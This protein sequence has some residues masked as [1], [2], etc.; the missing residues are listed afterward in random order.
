MKTTIRITQNDFK[1]LVR[2]KLKLFLSVDIVGSTH[3]KQRDKDSHAQNWLSLFLSFFAEFPTIFN[4]EIA[5]Q[6]EAH[7]H[8]GLDTVRL[9]KSLGDELIF[10]VELKHRTQAAVYLKAF[11]WA[12]REAAANWHTDSEA[13]ALKELHLKGAA[14]LAGFPVG[15]AE[16]P[17]EVRVDEKSMDGRDYI[18][19]LIDTG[20]RVKE[21]ASPRKLVVS[22]ELAYLLVCVGTSGLRFFYEG[23]PA[24]KGILK[25]K[26]Y[27]VIWLEFDVAAGDDR[28]QAMAE[29]NS[30]RDELAGRK[31]ADSHTLKKYLKAWIE[32]TKPCLGKPF[33]RGDEFDDLRADPEYEEQWN[34]TIEELRSVFVV[35]EEQGQESTV[36]SKRLP[37]EFM[38]LLSNLDASKPTKMT[39]R[40]TAKKAPRRDSKSGMK[41]KY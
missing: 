2:P 8:D 5:K 22:V 1:E 10:T 17:M 16:I 23:E 18:G 40:K 29:M 7:G 4:G 9:W 19:P 32:E 27:P 36:G 30:L 24:L 38:D 14:W 25:G 3:Y 13:P 21:Y 33:I 15:N 41:R 28:Y 34:R 37:K 6:K 26:P 31:H 20:F 39:G 11:T 35:E 12:L